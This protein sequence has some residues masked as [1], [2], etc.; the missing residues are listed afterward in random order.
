[1]SPSIQRIQRGYITIPRS[2]SQILFLALTAP[3]VRT[4]VVS[5]NNFYTFV[6]INGII[7]VSVSH[8]LNGKPKCVKLD[9]IS[10]YAE[11]CGTGSI[12]RLS[13]RTN[14]AIVERVISGGATA[15]GNTARRTASRRRR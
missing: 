3:N 5:D 4:N 2:H 15:E 13:D 11:K 7:T 6:K 9:R 10:R 14:G 12:V 1:M 8:A